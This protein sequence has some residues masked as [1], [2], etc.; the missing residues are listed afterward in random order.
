MH[1]LCEP[2]QD[3]VCTACA[4]FAVYALTMY[5]S[6]CQSVYA[7]CGSCVDHM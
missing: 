1:N 3:H 4:A 5:G 7:M 2:C 6:K